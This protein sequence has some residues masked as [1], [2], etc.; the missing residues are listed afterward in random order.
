MIAYHVLPCR[1]WYICNTAFSHYLCIVS[2]HENGSDW[3]PSWWINGPPTSCTLVEITVWFG[4]VPTSIIS[5]KCHFPW[6]L[7]VWLKTVVLHLLHLVFLGCFWCSRIH[8]VQIHLLPYI[9]YHGLLTKTIF[10][11]LQENEICWF[12]ES[13]KTHKFSMWAQCT[14]FKCYSR[15]CVY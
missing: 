9:K 3:W 10:S 5:S 2:F 13:S 14:V 6:Q 8:Y 7:K 11:V 1:R 12:W 4:H 15:L